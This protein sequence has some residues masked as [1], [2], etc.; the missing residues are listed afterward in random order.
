M[1]WEFVFA[2]CAAYVM[3]STMRSLAPR[4]GLVDVPNDRSVHVHHI[5]RGAGIGFCLA[6]VSAV[7]LFHFE[8]VWGFKWTFLAIF[9]VFAVGV[10]DDHRDTVPRTKFFVILFSTVLVA[11]DGIVINDLGIVF[12]VPIALGWFAMP[13]TLFAVAG[14]TNALNLID[15]LDGLAA[16]VSIV[17]LGSLMAVGYVHDDL[18]ITAVAGAFIAALAAFLV[19]NWHPATVFMGDSGSL[20]LGF[21]I[22]VLAIKSLA[23]IPA[24]SVFFIAALPILDTLVVMIRRKASG[25]SVFSADK[26]HTH[27]VLKQI[28]AWDIRRTVLFL[29]LVQLIYALIGLQVDKK[30]DGGMMLLFFIF[31]VALL[32]LFLSRMIKKQKRNC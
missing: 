7:S 32:Y 30:S 18:F 2:F 9:C 5:P 17:I 29:G 31:N 24:V 19:F 11:F 8:L 13:F 10:L 15:G 27:H 22:S 26:C 23:Y 1:G 3:V 28:F 12:G 4:L 25:R 21:V 6:A 14:F 20:T 16:T